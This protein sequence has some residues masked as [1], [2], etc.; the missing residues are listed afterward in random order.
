MNLQFD[1]L[2][3]RTK[4]HPPQGDDASTAK[5]D[6]GRVGRDEQGEAHRANSTPDVGPHLE[7]GSL[8]LKTWSKSDLRIAETCPTCI[9]R[10]IYI[11]GFAERRY[12]WSPLCQ[13]KA[14]SK[15]KY[16]SHVRS[17]AI[18]QAH[19]VSYLIL[20]WEASYVFWFT[21]LYAFSRFQLFFLRILFQSDTIH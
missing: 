7:L 1:I 3:K 10:Y 8:R 6:P 14:Y 16:K 2:A 15:T 21:L 17:P 20:V 13:K 18:G 11:W 5:A 19:I 4:E 12:T 9:T